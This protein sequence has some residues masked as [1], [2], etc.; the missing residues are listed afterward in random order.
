ME[1]VGIIILAI[2]V[3]AL[4]GSVRVLALELKATQRVQR[5]GVSLQLYQQLQ[6]PALEGAIARVRELGDAP[7][8]RGALAL[9][10]EDARCRALLEVNRYFSRVGA[11]VREGVADD[12]VFALMGPTIS[13][14]WHVSRPT[15]QLIK[16]KANQTT[17]DYFDWLYERWLNWEHWQRAD[18]GA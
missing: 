10:L 15:R 7:T 3:V 18:V 16:E 4:A 5:A 12:E 14:M 2:C 8:P 13:E 1:T 6:T 17:P 11:L 9:P